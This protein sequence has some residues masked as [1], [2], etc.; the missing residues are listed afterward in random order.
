MSDTATQTDAEQHTQVEQEQ[1]ETPPAQGDATDWEAEAKK[2]EKRAKANKS[3]V[4]K[5]REIEEAS[6]S[7]AERLAEA[8]RELA[9][10]RAEKERL[11]VASA[12]GV[13]PEL[14]AGPGD[15]LEAYA[16][17][18][19]KWRGHQQEQARQ[20]SGG[21]VPGVGKMPESNGAATLDEQITAAEK[22]KD[23]KLVSSL[24]AQKL[25]AI[26]RQRR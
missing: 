23:W 18:L 2:W 21:V 11:E 24:N 22:A 26:A 14:L 3:A 12:K 5:L 1:V 19:M 15:D 4:D 25:V 16:D 10:I 9:E 8:Q 13:P 7:E 17:A 6:K 20:S